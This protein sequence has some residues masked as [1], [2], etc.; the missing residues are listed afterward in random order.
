MRW[1]SSPRQLLGS[2]AIT[3]SRF[4]LHA[5]N[6]VAWARVSTP[7]PPRVLTLRWERSGGKQDRN[8][9]A[10]RMTAAPKVGART[11]VALWEMVGSR[12]VLTWG[13]PMRHEKTGSSRPRGTRS[14]WKG[15]I[16]S[17]IRIRFSEDLTPHERAKEAA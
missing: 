2:G 9:E 15:S 10:M 6:G 8:P 7:R 13:R 17:G 4:G 1:K 3:D 14:G 12:P 11:E 16:R 5:G